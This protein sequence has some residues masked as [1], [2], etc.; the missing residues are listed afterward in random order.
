[1][2]IVVTGS[3]GF[4]GKNLCLRLK[5]K[6]LYQVLEISRETTKEQASFFLSQAD[7]VFHLGGVNR[8]K[9]LDNFQNGNVD[10]T[11]YV[12]KTLEGHGRNV[13]IVF[14]SSTQVKQDN[15][16]GKSKL[17]AEK[18]MEDY[19]KRTGASIHIPKLRRGARAPIENNSSF[20]IF[21]SSLLR[22]PPPYSFGTVG[23][24]Q[25]FS[26][27]LSN[28][29]FDSGFLYFAFLPPHTSST[30]MFESAPL[31]IEEGQF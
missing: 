22:P 29:I 24:V 21:T 31:R 3:E 8:P 19:S 30:G 4:I 9:G 6:E 5:E 26:P 11:S 25:P 14:S 1:M 18:L 13:P 23:I 27:I 7:F 20:K 16:Y 12:V 17:A 2:R 15:E 28:Q 10:L